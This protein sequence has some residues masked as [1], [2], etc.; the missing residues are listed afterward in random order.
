[1]SEII[2]VV[3]CGAL[4]YLLIRNHNLYE[5]TLDASYELQML[6]FE[7][8]ELKTELIALRTKQAR[9]ISA[10]K[11]MTATLNTSAANNICNRK[12]GT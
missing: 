2:I 6:E 5:E 8:E 4:I 10:L 7:R 3:L 11:D 12:I 9:V 1:M